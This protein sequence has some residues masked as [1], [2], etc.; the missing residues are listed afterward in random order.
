MNDS[1]FVKED[2]IT[3]NRFGI[4]MGIK[5]FRVKKGFSQA[6]LADLMGISRATISK[7]ENGKFSIS[8]DYLAKFARHL[9]F[10]IKLL[11]N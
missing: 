2:F 10:D 3:S 8:I 7:I 6:H 4:G 9:G 11:D 1:Q 5:G